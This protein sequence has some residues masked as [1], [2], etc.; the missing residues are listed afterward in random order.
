ML[1]EA[2]DFDW[3]ALD[4]N[5]KILHFASGGGALPKAV[6]ESIDDGSIGIYIQNLPELTSGVVISNELLNYRQLMDK[7]LDSYL[8]DFA[9]ISRKG[10]FSF[11]KTFLGHPLD[12]RYHL[13]CRPAIK[14]LFQDI[15]IDLQDQLLKIRLDFD[16]EGIGNID[17]GSLI[18]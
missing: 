18:T 15:P 4:R 5:N 3:F 2:F 13:V 6:K 7:D 8:R 17:L 11:D 16:V 1:H 9:R 12:Q 10:L 14:L